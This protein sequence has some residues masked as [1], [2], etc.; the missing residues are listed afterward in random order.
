M[1][2]LDRQPSYIKGA[3]KTGPSC[4][5]ATKTSPFGRAA[6]LKND[7]SPSMPWMALSPALA[8]LSVLPFVQAIT[9]P[10]TVEATTGWRPGPRS[11]SVPPTPLR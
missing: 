1:S 2:G 10:R 5:P 8:H 3:T 9:V 6:R 11:S 4:S 7:A